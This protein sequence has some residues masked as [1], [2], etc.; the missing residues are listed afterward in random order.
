MGHCRLEFK[1]RLG[2]APIEAFLSDIIVSCGD[3]SYQ[4]STTIPL[5]EKITGASHGLY[6]DDWDLIEKILS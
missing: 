3:F 1:S 5:D 6:F 2:Y 4:I